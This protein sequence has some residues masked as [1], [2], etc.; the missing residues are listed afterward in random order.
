M[1]P[2][3]G[4]LFCFIRFLNVYFFKWT[5][6]GL[7]FFIFDFSIQSAVHKIFKMSMSEIEPWTS[8]VG[9]DAL[10]TEPQPL[11]S[12]SVLLS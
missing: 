7:F 2:W 9:S 11:A 12:S 6:L 5:F 1:T 3:T 4:T 10:P 8:A